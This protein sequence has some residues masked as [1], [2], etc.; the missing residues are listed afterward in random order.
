MIRSVQ[1]APFFRAF[2]L[3][4]PIKRGLKRMARVLQN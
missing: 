2:S 3:E 4:F 1:F